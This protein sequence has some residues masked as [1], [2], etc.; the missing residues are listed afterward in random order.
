MGLGGGGDMAGVLEAS[1][2]KMHLAEWN[3]RG[4]LWVGGWVGGW[5]DGFPRVCI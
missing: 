3:G 5:M 4:R 1:S 2:G